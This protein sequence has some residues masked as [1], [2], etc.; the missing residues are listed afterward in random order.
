VR[1]HLATWNHQTKGQ[2]VSDFEGQDREA[3]FLIGDN[4]PI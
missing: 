1:C 2:L 3:P 4:T